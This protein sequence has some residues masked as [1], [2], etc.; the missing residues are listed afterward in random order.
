MVVPQLSSL[1]TI[2]LVEAQFSQSSLDV[3]Q[4]VL[5]TLEQGRAFLKHRKGF[6]QVF[7]PPLELSDKVLQASQG[8]IVGHRV[9]GHV[10]SSMW[11]NVYRRRPLGRQR[12]GDG[13]FALR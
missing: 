3:A 6:V 11:S 8:F 7:S 10:S 13:W 4:F 1:T 12:I 5:T 9:F 2:G